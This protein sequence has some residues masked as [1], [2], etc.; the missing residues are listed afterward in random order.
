M[1]S[2]CCE[3]CGLCVLD[4][5]RGVLGAGVLVDGELRERDGTELCGVVGRDGA[6]LDEGELRD[7][8]GA[9]LCGVMGLDGCGE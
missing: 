6:L 2:E 8:D 7:R 9:E 3:L 5:V 1:L 4:L